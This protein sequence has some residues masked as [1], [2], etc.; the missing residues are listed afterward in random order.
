MPILSYDGLS[1]VTC[2]Y[3]VPQLLPDGTRLY[4]DV[5]RPAGGG[6]HPVLLARMPY[7]KRTVENLGYRHPIWYA[8]H[9]YM[10]VM[11]DVRGRWQSE[12]D[13]YP[14][15]HEESDGAVAIEWA[16]RLP[17]ANGRVGMYGF[18]Y[19]G[20]T[21]LLAATARPPSL[22]AIAPAM[23]SS[24]YYDGW[25]YQGGAFSLAFA[26]SWATDL[27]AA[28]ALR[29]GDEAGARPLMEAA[30]SCRQFQSLAL[31]ELAVLRQAK[32]A[33]FFFDWLDHPSN[34][35]YW[36]RWSLEMRY[37]SLQIP[38]LHVGGWYDIFL[39]GTLRNF[40]GILGAGARHQHLIVGPWAHMPWS[41]KV[42]CLDF[43]PNAASPIDRRQLLFFDRFLKEE[44]VEE[45]ERVEVFV[46][47]EN[48]WRAFS[49][50]PPLEAESR[51]LFL[52]SDGAANTDAGDGSLAAEAPQNEPPDV[53]VYAPLSPVHSAGGSSCCFPT[54]APMGP[55]WQAQAE[56]DPGVL[57]Y[58]SPVYGKAVCII[59]P[60]TVYLWAVSNVR[61]TDFVAKLCVVRSDGGSINLCQ[62]IIRARYRNSLEEAS[63]IEP[64]KAYEYAIDLGAIAVRLNPGER[65]R[66]LVTSSDFPHWDRNTNTGEAWGAEG[67]SQVKI[68]TQ[69]ILHERAHASRVDYFEVPE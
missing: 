15:A 59:G 36:Q 21:Q 42:G 55:A 63:L 8:R 32:E 27:V 25:T 34:D 56:S 16:A 44:T 52:H 68:A 13:F 3:D 33:Q 18:S 11:Q 24:Q 49:S 43:G 20:A 19:A 50:W 2:E 4:A 9:G 29:R 26:L 35:S 14:F 57:V 22:K 7:D 58:T 12:G 60:V 23:T 67:P 62:G 48:R 1:D 40:S 10:V 5:Y 37:S 30:S 17:G 41:Q 65:L 6:T 51:S 64:G 28:Q 54:T 66:L 61:D 69:L 39:R 46:M 31:K 47:G 38:A 45:L 53:Y